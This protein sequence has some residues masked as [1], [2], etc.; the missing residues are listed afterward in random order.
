[1]IVKSNVVVR[2]KTGRCCSFCNP[3]NLA[4]YEIDCLEISRVNFFKDGSITENDKVFICRKCIHL[5]N[6]TLENNSMSTV[7]PVRPEI[8]ML[9]NKLGG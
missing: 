1:M 9:M 8:V 5:A 2:F 7:W 3:V 6:I 4:D